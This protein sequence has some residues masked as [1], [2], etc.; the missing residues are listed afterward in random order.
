MVERI[1]LANKTI[2]G[3]VIELIGML[4][5]AKEDAMRCDDGNK[6]AGTRVRG[7]LMEVKKRCD[8]LRKEIIA[9]RS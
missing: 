2:G 3:Q 9:L 8:H 7:V 5:N 6:A 4:E 1:K